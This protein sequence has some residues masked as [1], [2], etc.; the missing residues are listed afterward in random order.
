MESDSTFAFANHAACTQL[1]K[2]QH[3]DPISHGNGDDN[4]LAI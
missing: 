1:G 2:I 3:K 4:R